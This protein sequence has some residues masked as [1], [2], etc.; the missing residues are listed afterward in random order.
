MGSNRKQASKAPKN[1][2]PKPKDGWGG[3][4]MTVFEEKEDLRRW[5]DSLTPEEQERG[6]AEADLE[7]K[8]LKAAAERRAKRKGA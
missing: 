4:H 7:I 2:K 8:R 6:D 5:W 1:G 3:D